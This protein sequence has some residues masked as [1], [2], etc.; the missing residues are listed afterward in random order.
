MVKVMRMRF[1]KPG[2]IAAVICLFIVLNGA[3]TYAGLSVGSIIMN[4][5]PDKLIASKWFEESV[6]TGSSIED[7][8]GDPVADGT[9]ITVWA[10]SPDIIY[11]EQDQDP[12]IP[13]I[14][15]L[16]VNGQISFT[17][18]S[19]MQYALGTVT[20]YAADA[21]GSASGS[22]N[23]E[24]IAGPPTGPF[25]ITIDP[26]AIPADGTSIAVVTGGPLNDMWGHVVASAL[27]TVQTSMGT[28]F[29]DVDPSTAGRQV[30]TDS[31]GMFSFI[32]QAPVSSGIG[33][34]TANSVG[35]DASGSSSIIFT[36]VCGNGII[37]GNEECD[38]HNTVAGDGCSPDCRVE[39]LDLDGDGFMS[40][41][42]D[43]NDGDPAINPNTKWY[44]D[45]DGDSY[46]NPSIYIYQCEQ[47]RGN[48]RG[49]YV[50]DGTDCDDSDICIYPGGPPIKIA[51]VVLACFYDIQ[52]AYTPH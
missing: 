20:V 15:I 38:D 2:V 41:N 14:Q 21:I 9:P 49:N 29:E 44:P 23:I 51:G 12:N 40:C 24:F 34:V 6:V 1:V 11:P 3:V 30:L 52:E 28:I 8:E 45:D 31:S 35:G 37:E 26:Y 43:C 4:A 50:L 47:P 33:T 18:Y 42:D 27:V 19:V 48:Y 46:G 17:V 16:T 7:I 13:G 10:S 5:V 25:T 22:V 32:I 39:C 36:G